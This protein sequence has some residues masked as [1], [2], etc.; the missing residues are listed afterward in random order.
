MKAAKVTKPVKLIISLISNDE[1]LFVRVEEELKKKFGTIDYKSPI[2]AFSNTDYYREELGDN[3]KKSFISFKK[4]INP[5]KLAKIKIFTNKLEG[6]FAEQGKRRVN[7]DPGY[8]D[9]AKLVLLSAKDFSHRIALG[10]GIF[11]EVTLIFKDKEFRSLEWT[12]PDY[13]SQEYL[14]IFKDIRKIYS[15]Q[16][17]K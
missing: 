1:A 5:A 15:Q 6:H 16:M 9:L 3:L 13:R 11:A 4:L 8:L 14:E 17:L 7:I 10:C 2:M 12:Y